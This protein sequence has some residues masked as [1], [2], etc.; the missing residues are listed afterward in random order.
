MRMTIF[1]D[2]T[3]I[4]LDPSWDFYLVWHSCNY[5]K[6]LIDEALKIVSADEFPSSELYQ[7]AQNLVRDAEA[8][9]HEQFR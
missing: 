7:K 3:P 5:A 1:M 8:I 9:L 6:A 4:H 2:D